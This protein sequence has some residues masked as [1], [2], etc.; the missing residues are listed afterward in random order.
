[1]PLRRAGY[2]RR[3]LQM[4]RAS[5]SGRCAMFWRS[6][7]SSAGERPLEAPIVVEESASTAG[8]AGSSRT[9]GRSQE[10]P[11]PVATVTVALVGPGFMVLGVGGRFV[12]RALGGA[13][14][15][16]SRLAA[17]PPPVVVLDLHATT[18]V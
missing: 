6:G 13:V 9:V 2:S 11:G 18:A 16:L 17:L 8:P 15:R 1:M 3:S 4:S 7:L 5:C 14:D 12:E 10:L